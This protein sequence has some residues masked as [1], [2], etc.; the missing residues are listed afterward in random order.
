MTRGGDLGLECGESQ[1]GSGNRCSSG[2]Q[3]AC[4]R[5]LQRFLEK[6]EGRASEDGDTQG[7]AS[8][9]DRCSRESV[10]FGGTDSG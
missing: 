3:L 5:G 9:W 1:V 8:T 6:D 7:V 10:D 4:H 2:E